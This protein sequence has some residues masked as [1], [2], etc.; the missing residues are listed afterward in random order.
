MI[1]CFIAE[2][3]GQVVTSEQVSSSY[4][5]LG[6]FNPL[7][8][9]LVILSEMDSWTDYSAFDQLVPVIMV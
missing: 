5:A 7:F 6:W 4:T 1:D 8:S 2:M 9:C 3:A